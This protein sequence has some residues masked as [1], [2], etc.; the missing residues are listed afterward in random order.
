MSKRKTERQLNLIAVLLEARVPVTLEEIRENVSGYKQDD[1]NSFKRMFE[2]DKRELRDMGIPIE[3]EPTDP[4]GEEQGYRIPKDAY[5]LPEIDFDPDER[6][7]LWLLHKLVWQGAFPFSLEA[8]KALLKLT[9]D[10]GAAGTETLP[11]MDWCISGDG[12]V[13][14][15]LSVLL[16]AVIDQKRARFDYLSLHDPEPQGRE[17]DPYGLFF[18]H[19]SWYLV[20]FCHLRSDIRCFRVSRMRGEV[21]IP[22]ARSKAPDFSRPPGF[23]VR[24]YSDKPPWQFE[25][26]PEFKVTMRF[27]PK[28]A[29]WVEENVASYGYAFRRQKDGGGTLTLKARSRDTL[30]AW[31]LS[32]GEDAEILGPPQ[33]REAMRSRL[34]EIKSALSPR[35]G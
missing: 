27:S 18:E 15:R 13:E 29:W 9:P 10:L 34:K 35:K 33:V 20:G 19:G 12:Q 11:T 32:F 17:A 28:L 23:R 5:Y 21:E 24:D 16:R 30:L 26:G 2:R 7:A 22:E 6:L 1:L 25:D 8:R 31:A 4:F 3:V 14:E